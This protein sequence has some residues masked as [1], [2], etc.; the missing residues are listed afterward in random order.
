MLPWGFVNL[1]LF[2]WP[3][4]QGMG[5]LSLSKACLILERSLRH[6]QFACELMYAYASAHDCLLV[7]E[8]AYYAICPCVCLY[9]LVH[10]HAYIHV[11]KWGR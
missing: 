5:S 2:P 7:Q 10:A 6:V 8:Y 11:H 1:Q 4:C 3:T 9:V